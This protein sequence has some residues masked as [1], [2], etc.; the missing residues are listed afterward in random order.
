MTDSDKVR[1][2]KQQLQEYI[3]SASLPRHL[4]SRRSSAPSW[5]HSYGA[6]QAIPI[7]GLRT[8][9]RTSR[10]TTTRNPGAVVA[11][12]LKEASSRTGRSAGL[13][14]PTIIQGGAMRSG[15]S[16]HSART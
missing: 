9:L 14:N 5:Q 15:S 11:D 4:R 7:T 16:R 12:I 8:A 6:Q 3:S 10:A 1:D 13:S 2:R